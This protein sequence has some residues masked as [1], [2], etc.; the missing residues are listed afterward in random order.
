MSSPFPKLSE[1]SIYL[2]CE[3]NYVDH[4]PCESNYVDQKNYRKFTQT[5][6]CITKNNFSYYLQS[7]F[8]TPSGLW[9][10]LYDHVFNN[11]FHDRLESIKYN[12][13]LS[14]TRNGG[15]SR[16][17]LYQELGL[18]SRR[19]RW[20]SGKLRLFIKILKNKLP[21]YLF[22]LILVRCSCHTSRN[23]H[24]VPIFNIKPKILYRVPWISLGIIG[25][26]FLFHFSL[27]RHCFE[28]RT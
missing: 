16:E 19:L 25:F 18:D 23:V 4:I 12:A 21:H 6:Y 9:R 5:R 3:S 26:W 11:S 7:L 14:I 8:Q 28:N 17:K 15:T 10:F 20:W 2:P 27:L 1:P 22:Y 13:S 24:S